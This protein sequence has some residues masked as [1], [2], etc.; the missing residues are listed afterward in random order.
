MLK[1]LTIPA[2][3]LILLAGAAAPAAAD[4]GKAYV[5]KPAP[6]YSY[7]TQST[8]NPPASQQTQK[9]KKFDPNLDFETEAVWRNLRPEWFDD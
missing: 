4:K 6:K 2:L 5:F 7:E 8:T 9:R 1:K 3:G